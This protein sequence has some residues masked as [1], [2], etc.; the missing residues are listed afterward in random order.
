MNGIT[1]LQTEI[2]IMNKSLGETIKLLRHANDFSAS[3][4]AEK[5]GVNKS[6]VSLLESDSRTPSIN[7]LK[8]LAT[9]L[10]VPLS[11]LVEVSTGEESGKKNQNL[12]S[13]FSEFEALERKL[14]NVISKLSRSKQN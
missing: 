3:E 6:Y 5:I 10:N 1:Q 14:K 8:D 12:R 2:I 7:V 4:L 9:E 11:F 13:V